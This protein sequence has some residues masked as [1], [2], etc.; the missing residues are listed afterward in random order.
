MKVEMSTV[1]WP[2]DLDWDDLVRYTFPYQS[3]KK[4]CWFGESIVYMD[5]A[6]MVFL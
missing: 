1:L 3:N 5:M 6:V 2:K 4:C